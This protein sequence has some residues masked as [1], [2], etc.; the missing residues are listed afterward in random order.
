MKTSPNESSSNAAP[1]PTISSIGPNQAGLAQQITVTINGTNLAN[2]S[3]V[4]FDLAGSEPRS[5]PAGTINPATQTDT[6]IQVTLPI[7]Q[8]GFTPVNNAVPIDITLVVD[9]VST[10]LPGLFTFQLPTVTGI[11]PAVG[12]LAGKTSFIVSGQYF[13]GA[14]DVLFGQ[15]STGVCKVLSDTSISCQNPN[16]GTAG[17]VNVSVKVQ[18]V[19]S[20]NQVP[21][22]YL[23]VPAI[24][25]VSPNNGPV[26]TVVSLT[27]SGFSADSTVSFGGTAATATVV[28]PTSITV[29]VPSGVSGIVDITVTAA[30]GTSATCGADRFEV[31]TGPFTIPLT[32]D[33]RGANLP[34][35]TPAYAYIVGEVAQPG[36]VND[37]YWFNPATQ[38]PQLMTTGDNS[39]LAATFPGSST[40]PPA[41]QAA[42][43]ANYPDAWANYS[44]PLSLSAANTINL[45]TINPTNVPGLSTGTAAFSGRIY[46]SLGLPILPFTVK[47]NGYA[48]PV[49]AAAAS[50]VAGA[51]CLFDWIEFSFDSNQ[52]FNGNTTQVDQFGLALTLN[53]TPPS[54]PTLIQG[55]LSQS[56][57][58]IIEAFSVGGTVPTPFGAGTLVVS[59]P[60]ALAGNLGTPTAPLYVYPKGT[61][62]LRLMSPNNNT[63]SATP[64]ATLASYFDQEINT[65]YANW[66][67]T[68]VVTFDP[69][70]KHYTGFVPTTG[71]NQGSLCFYSGQLTSQPTSPPAFVLVGQSGENI[72]SSDVWQ[73]ANSLALPN[74]SAAQ[75]NV[76]KILA[77]AFNRGIAGYSLTDVYSANCSAAFYPTGGTWNTWAQQFHAV[78]KNTLAYGFPYDDVCD[79]NP[80]INLTETLSVTITLAPLG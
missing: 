4:S 53:G 69:A 10:Q 64:D 5:G 59:V 6:Q 49:P 63:A 40:L 52:N 11:S 3:L 44:I 25:Q 38:L 78:S 62:H 70:S 54:D 61:T 71:A 2:V 51:L 34:A 33:L 24:T 26:G 31:G 66:A 17:S 56:R 50:S 72:T 67:T 55:V 36:G 13:T 14:G 74:A 19:Q 77:A 43:A 7:C 80:S 60:A 35:G 18:G 48:A 42:L 39:N 45:A 47:S 65:W 76:G 75:L 15:A 20:T 22:N 58:E 37:F 8:G 21:F 30:G 41:A 23:A 57:A 73:C 28:S 32:L 16:Q 27:G 1:V 79:Q 68:P 29:P 9:G 46:L 12:P